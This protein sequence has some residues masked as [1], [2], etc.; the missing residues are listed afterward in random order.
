MSAS[1]PDELGVLANSSFAN[2]VERLERLPPRGRLAG[3]QRRRD[4][5]GRLRTS[6]L[7]QRVQRG[8]LCRRIARVAQN[9]RGSGGIDVGA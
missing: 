6:S 4:E 1:W 3:A 7:G 9:F 8:I 2:L 5:V